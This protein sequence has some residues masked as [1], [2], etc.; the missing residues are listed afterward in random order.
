[1]NK[2]DIL[3]QLNI[4]V[5]LMNKIN[6]GDDDHENSFGISTNLIKKLTIFYNHW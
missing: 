6:D 2:I 4:L 3:K 1:M 5:R